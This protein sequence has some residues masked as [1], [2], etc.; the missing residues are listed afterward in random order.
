[1]IR[2]EFKPPSDFVADDGGSGSSSV[3]KWLGIGCGV[4]AL[5]FGVLLLFGTWKTVSCCGDVQDFV[6]VNMEVGQFG[7]DFGSTLASGDVDR[8]RS[9]MTDELASHW[10]AEKLGAKL[11]EHRSFFSQA[12]PQVRNFNSKHAG[13]EALWELSIDYVPPSGSEKL[14]VLLEVVKVED[15]DPP[16]FEAS[17]LSFEVREHQMRTEPPAQAVTTFH[18]HLRSGDYETA[19]ESMS[20]DFAQEQGLDAF[21]DFISSQ[22]PVFRRGGIEVRSITYPAQNS[23]RVLVLAQGRD[24]ER[25]EIEYMLEQPNPGLPRWVISAV[26]PTYHGADAEGGAEEA[27]SDA[28]DD[29]QNDAGATGDE[30][31]GD[32]GAEPAAEDDDG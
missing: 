21:R 3:W 32:S 26:T 27:G 1:M 2:N 7:N 5:L 20:E 30:E 23:A 19:Y 16:Q 29:R 25:A 15:S 8:A 9:K 17:G 14:V 28:G 11:E 6:K 10:S 4:I 12:S 24:G 31:G 22:E 18:R 13:G